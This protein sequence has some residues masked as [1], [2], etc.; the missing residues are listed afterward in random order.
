M[1]DIGGGQTQERQLTLGGVLRAES[2][3]RPEALQPVARRCGLGVGDV[4][5][6]NCRLR[7]H[8]V[9]GGHGEFY[10]TTKDPTW[11]SI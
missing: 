9:A 5:W 11:T 8:A 10:N 6:F 2:G 3:E 7:E 4:F 1:A